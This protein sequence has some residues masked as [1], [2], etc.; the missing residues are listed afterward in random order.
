V[1]YERVGEEKSWEAPMKRMPAKPA[2]ILPLEIM[3]VS[4]LAE[5]LQCHP[6]TIYRMLKDK[7]IFAFKLGSDWRFEKSEINSWLRKS[8]VG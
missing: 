4:T 3:T 2:P 6:S 7:K 1:I 5:Y 8:S